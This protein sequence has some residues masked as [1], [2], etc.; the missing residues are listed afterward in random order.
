MSIQDFK[1]FWDLTYSIFIEYLGDLKKSLGQGII[2]KSVLSTNFQNFQKQSVS[3][4]F[5]VSANENQSLPCKAVRVFPT[6]FSNT[7]IFSG[8]A[9]FR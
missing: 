3:I 6:G 4:V 9:H 2:P 8:P 5:T 7:A 1:E